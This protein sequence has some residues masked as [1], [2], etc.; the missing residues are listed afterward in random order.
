MTQTQQGETPDGRI[1]VAVFGVIAVPKGSELDTTHRQFIIEG[2]SDWSDMHTNLKVHHM[3][4]QDHPD[5]QGM[6]IAGIM[7][8]SIWR[9]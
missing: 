9:Y 5:C 3:G 8:S 6:G 7:T 1:L 2:A 4:T